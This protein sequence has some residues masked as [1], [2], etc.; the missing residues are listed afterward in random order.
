MGPIYIGAGGWAYL[1]TKEKHK[2][3]AYSK[4][5]NFVEVNSTFYTF[6]KSALVRLWRRRVPSEFVF[7]VRCHRNLTHKYE[8]RPVDEAFNIFDRMVEI[9][10][11][12][13]APILH[14]QTPHSLE[15]D[16][17]RARLTRDFFSSTMTKDVR[18]AWEIRGRV[19]EEVVRLM[20]DFEIVQCVDISKEELAVESHMLYTRLFG[21]GFHTLYQFDDEELKQIED[22]AKG[23]DFKE[24]FLTF[25]SLRMYE[26]AGRLKAHVEEG[27]FP[28]LKGPFGVDDLKRALVDAVFPCS[29]YRLIRDHGWKVVNMSEEMRVHVSKLLGEPHD[30]VYKNIDE[31][32]EEVVKKTH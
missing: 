23:Y 13:K 30:R 6:P 15:F 17:I 25:H 1:D 12:L 9:C 29:K 3:E 16:G 14:L 24:K 19:S 2:L 4:K 26:D 10:R 20:E 8:L 32:L 11:E 27:T 21:R 28:S 31:L 18:L 22:K 7:T 5:F